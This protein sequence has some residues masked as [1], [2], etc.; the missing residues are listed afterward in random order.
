MVGRASRAPVSR[1]TRARRRRTERRHFCEDPGV[2]RPIVCNNVKRGQSLGVAA[3][4][5]DHRSSCRALERSE[6]KNRAVIVLEEKLEQP[7]TEPADAVVQNKV[8][9]FLSRAALALV[10]QSC[11][12]NSE[13]V[14]R[15]C[16]AA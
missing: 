15:K 1:A 2:T 9:A 5:R 12:N 13:H 10:N 6:D 11:S 7:V 8:S 4:T 3:E 14:Y 16:Q